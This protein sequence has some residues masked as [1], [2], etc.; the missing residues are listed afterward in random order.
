[1]TSKRSLKKLAK[2]YSGYAF[3]Q[4]I[5]AS[6]DGDKFIIQAKDISQNKFV[7]DTNNLV[8]TSLDIPRSNSYLRENDI[9]LVSRGSGNSNF[10][11]TIYKSSEKNVV[12]SSTLNII[13]VKGQKILP[14]YLTIFLNSSDGQNLIAGSLSGSYIRVITL[15]NLEDLSVPVPPLDQQQQIISIYQNARR[16]D[17][18]AER[19]SQIRKNIITKILK[20]TTRSK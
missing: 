19:K 14:E 8:K 11:S 7:T 9:L 4:A 15:K 3:R 12:A 6:T 1:M 17:E 10:K 20:E 2:I 5:E 16:Q 18:I 13:R